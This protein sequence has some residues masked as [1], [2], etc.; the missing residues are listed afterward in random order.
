MV[1][2]GAG[3]SVGVEEFRAEALVTLTVVE[4]KG[5][6][7]TWGLKKAGRKAELAERLLEAS[8]TVTQ[9][10]GGV[11][12]LWARYGERVTSLV[13]PGN[14]SD[15][16]VGPAQTQYRG[17]IHGGRVGGHEKLSCKTGPHEVGEVIVEL[18]SDD[19]LQDQLCLVKQRPQR[20]ASC[21][22]RRPT[23]Q[24]TC[25]GVGVASSK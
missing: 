16:S 9:V 14:A 22:A 24:S 10:Q 15:L 25:G 7:E 12:I 3:G 20:R 4:W 13:V 19:A 11:Y 23:G 6:C 8:S 21:A 18:S 2:A 5:M 17:C 1:G